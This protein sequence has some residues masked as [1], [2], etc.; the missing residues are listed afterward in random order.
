MPVQL[1]KRIV[2]AAL[3][4]ERPYELRDTTVRGL[5]L[6]VQPSGYKA[7]II[8]WAWGKRRT[9]G[10]LGHLTL[11]QARAHAALAMAEVI[12]QGLPS[13]AKAKPSSCTLS[14]FLTDHYGPWVVGEL[15]TGVRSLQIIR[16]AFPDLMSRQLT[17]IDAPAIEHWWKAR[18]ATNSVHTGVPVCKA[19]LSRQFAALRSALSKA[20]EWKLLAANPLLGVRNKSAE[21]RVV[22]RYLTPAEESR[23]RSVLIARDAAAVSARVSGNVWRARRK[24]PALALIPA[25]GYMDHLTPVV[26]LAMNTGLRRGEL[27]SLTW[28]DVDLGAKMITVRAERAKSGRQRHVPLNVEALEVLTRWRA[29]CGDAAV[30]FEPN[31]VKTAWV[32][33]LAKAKITNCR[34]HDL[35]HHFASRLVTKGV[36]LNTVRE[37]LGHA[38]LK[39]TLRYA[40]LA[41][42]HLAA[43]VEKMAA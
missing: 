8:Q 32:K 9:L 7:W 34:F 11:E 36:D 24:A 42:D 43:A 4:Q 19:T 2:T 40:H 38:D 35:R 31:D 14:E 16:A 6:R 28:N 22:I 13:I 5:I 37:L 20:V 1:T 12:Q 23:L 10:Q 25:G 27:L 41:P 15:K 33:L 3:P 29:Q 39:M 26:L 18:L 21:G 17:A 30:V